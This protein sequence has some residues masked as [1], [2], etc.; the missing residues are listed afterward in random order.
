[1]LEP[2]IFPDS[3]IEDDPTLENDPL[4]DGLISEQSPEGSTGTSKDP[5]GQVQVDI[6]VAQTPVHK[7]TQKGNEGNVA[8]IQTQADI[9]KDLASKVNQNEQFFLVARRGASLSR[10]ISLWQRGAA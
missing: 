8:H 3:Y 5:I 4:W 10:M 2:D 9:L 7:D 6:P 1:M